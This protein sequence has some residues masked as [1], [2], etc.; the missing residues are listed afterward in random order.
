M[1]KTSSIFQ[2]YAM[3]SP[4]LTTAYDNIQ[5]FCSENTHWQ[6]R[7]LANEYH[8]GWFLCTVC[9]CLPCPGLPAM[10]NLI[11]VLGKDLENCPH[12]F[13][14][15]ESKFFAGVRC[16]YVCS[17]I[18]VCNRWRYQGWSRCRLILWIKGQCLSFLF[19]F[20]F[21]LFTIVF[22]LFHSCIEREQKEGVSVWCSCDLINITRESRHLKSIPHP[23]R[24]PTPIPDST[25]IHKNTHPTPDTRLPHLPWP[26]CLFLLSV[27]GGSWEIS[28]N[29]WLALN[30]SMAQ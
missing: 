15:F 28:W 10:G 30:L 1:K 13:L 29:C 2:I 9:I 5:C 6:S 25:H 4:S 17:D 20:L 27:P 24:P 16:V 22:T 26:T 18:C 11:K 14:D 8:L 23:I 19:Y 3:H 7:S 12:F 21:A